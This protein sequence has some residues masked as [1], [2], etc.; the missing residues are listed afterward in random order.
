MIFTHVS[1]M[2]DSIE[3]GIFGDQVK[4][5]NFFFLSCSSNHSFC[6]IMLLKEATAIFVYQTGGGQKDTL[7]TFL[8]LM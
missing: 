3:M 4:T 5:L 2:L 1:Q 7:L 6:S 8:E